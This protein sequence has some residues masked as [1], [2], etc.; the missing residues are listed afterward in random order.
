MYQIGSQFFNICLKE[1]L[2]PR[3]ARAALSGT[4]IA[5]F[6]TGSGQ[7]LFFLSVLIFG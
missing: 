1:A 6:Q 5:G 7:T 2:R 3:R 4:G